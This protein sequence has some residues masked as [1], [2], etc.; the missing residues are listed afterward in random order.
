[1]D[2]E[3]LE[4]GFGV[5]GSGK[6]GANVKACILVVLAVCVGVCA[7][8]EEK[9]RG[10]EG[11]VSL[12]NGKDLGGWKVPEGD[13]GHW[14]VVD[15]MIDYDARSEAKGE[16]SLWTERE[17]G[18]FVLR[19]DWRIKEVPFTN[20]NVFY[21]LPD[22]THAK[23]MHGKPLKLALPDSDSGV[24][25]RGSAKNQAN[26]W[27]WPIGSGEFYGYRMDEK[28][29]AEVR[30]GATPKHQADKPVGDWNTFEITMKGERVTVALNGV[31]VI[32][33]ARLPGV[34][35]KGAIGLQH[36]GSMKDGRWTSPPA[37]VQFRN[38]YVKQMQ[39]AE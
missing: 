3:G 2:V 31:V 37:M 28:M 32:E 11:W 10:A 14:K 15:G 35:E 13:G 23:D 17:F 24:M 7:S 12:F 20:P 38:I 4:V 18:D 5:R 21:V 19:V 39:N 26:I 33:E 1:V 16:K 22:G 34:K 36:H 6:R 30:A 29:P 27:C 8:A 25:V 9:G